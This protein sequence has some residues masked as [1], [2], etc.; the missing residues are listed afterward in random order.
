MICCPWHPFIVLKFLERYLN[1]SFLE[2]TDVFDTDVDSFMHCVCRIRPW[3]S[4]CMS[5]SE[6]N[7]ED[8]KG[9]ITSDLSFLLP[10]LTT[11]ACL[12]VD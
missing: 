7:R 10:I 8:H 4:H 6:R 11:M 2:D 5:F 1:I 9:H 3:L 12:C